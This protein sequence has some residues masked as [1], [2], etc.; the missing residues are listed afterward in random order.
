[1]F[2]LTKEHIFFPPCPTEVYEVPEEEV[3]PFCSLTRIALRQSTNVI[4]K[5]D[6]QSFKGEKWEQI[7]CLHLKL[8]D[9]SF[10]EKLA[11]QFQRSAEQSKWEGAEVSQ[12]C[13]IVI[14]SGKQQPKGMLSRSRTAAK[15]Q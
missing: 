9:T 14:Q 11:N 3:R 12:S 8:S 2:L 13:V 6:D 4:V 10:S 5:K 7:S 1:M 15:E